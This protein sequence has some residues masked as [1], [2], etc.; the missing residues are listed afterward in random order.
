VN[1]YDAPSFEHFWR[2][3]VRMHSRPATQLMHAAATLTA[4][5]LVALGIVW[6]RPLLIALAPL[7]DY[8]IAQLAHRLFQRNRTQP[9]RHPRWHLRA[10][11]RML[12]LVL[13]GRI[14]A[15]TRRPRS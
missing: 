6:R 13:T 1:P 4:A 2:W 3:Y 15:E 7:A 5:A 9:W 8:A 14:R 10:E 11:L 12:R